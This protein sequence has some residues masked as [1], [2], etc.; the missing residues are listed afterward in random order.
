MENL[1]EGGNILVKD[2]TKLWFKDLDKE[3][4]KI[5]YKNEYLGKCAVCRD[6]NM[7]DRKYLPINHTVEYLDTF[8]NNRLDYEI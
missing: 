2:I 1:I 6:Y 8:K 3:N 5:F 4:I 7:E